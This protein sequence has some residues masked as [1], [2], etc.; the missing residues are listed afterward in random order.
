[1]QSRS[2]LSK[3]NQLEKLHQ[4]RVQ[5]EELRKRESTGESFVAGF[6]G[7]DQW[8]KFAELTWIRSGGKIKRFKPF[9]I[10][11][12]L[13]QSIS[14]H[15]YSII[16][17]SRQV[18]AS[19][20]ICSYLLCRALTEPG[21]SACVFSKTA[22]D[23][24]SL[25]KRIRAQA[26]S[27]A[28]S[29]IEFTTESNSELSFRG[30]GTIHFLAA[31]ARAARGIPSVSVVVL[32]ECGFLGPEAEQIFTAVQPTMAT[33]GN[34]PVTGG[35]MILCSTPNGLG[36]MFA[37]LWYTAEDWNK[38]KIHYSD[39]PIY[40]KDPDWA[41]KTRLKSKLS[42]RNWRQ[43]YELD[44]VASEAQIYDPE[45]VEL[46]CNGQTIEYGLVGREYIMAVD[47]ASSQGEDYWCS[48]VLDITCIPYRVVNVFRMRHKSSD[49]CI[50]Q[51]VEQAE[52]FVPSKV[53]VEKNGVGQIVSEVLSM[54][55][56]KYQ[57][58]PYN[59]N[60]QNKISNTDR[61]S[62]LL[63]REELMLPRE[64]FYQELLMFQQMANGR[65]EAG[66]GSHDDSVMSLSLALS[67]VAETP[68]ADWLEIL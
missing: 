3:L 31:T 40:N 33:L 27:I 12:E 49:Y 26:A 6:P 18:G 5:A 43:E 56:A 53:I 32:D 22:A 61:I 19:E 51:I 21:F 60:K 9:Q 64:P 54:K 48:I 13:I 63:E 28:D 37:N 17:K 57:V 24:G 50:K 23:S 62:Y 36:N 14:Q 42:M 39:I 11:K 25:G 46:A 52:N 58:L 8:D 66:E 1:M 44:F 20:S 35:K 55:L 7:A 2:L 16:L 41:E 59:T 15:Q 67:L 47:P 68:T 10:Q 30:R 38:F 34:D 65:R 4:E 45:L 29:D